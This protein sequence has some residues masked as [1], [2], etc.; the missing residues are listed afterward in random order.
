MFLTISSNRHIKALIYKRPS[1]KRLNNPKWITMNGK[2]Y[3]YDPF[4]SVER[5][6]TTIRTTRTKTA[7]KKALNAHFNDLCILLIR[8]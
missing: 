8:I 3:S 1:E 7:K 4:A 6:T 2:G 5:K